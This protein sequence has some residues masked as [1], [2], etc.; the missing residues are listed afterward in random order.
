MLSSSSSEDY[1]FPKKRSFK[2]KTEPKKKKIVKNHPKD[3]SGS[4]KIHK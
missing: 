4:K 2:K 1:E 3:S